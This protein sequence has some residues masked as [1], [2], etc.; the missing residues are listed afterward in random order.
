MLENKSI[1]TSGVT[2]RFFV[3]DDQRYHHILNPYTGYPVENNILSVTIVS[4]RSVV[5]D[6]LATG[7]FA[8]GVEDAFKTIETLENVQMVIVTKDKQIFYSQTLEDKI[9]IF[10]VSYEGIQK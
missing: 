2:E 4:D 10:D 6:A 9:E 5:G 1:V 7:M 3:V 8:L